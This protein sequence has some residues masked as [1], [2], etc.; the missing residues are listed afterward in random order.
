M[1]GREESETTYKAWNDTEA[2]AS[3]AIGLGLGALS[4]FPID[5]RISKW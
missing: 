4:K 5:L 1:T 2:K 3:D